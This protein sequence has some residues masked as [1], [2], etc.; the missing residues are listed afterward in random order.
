MDTST[1]QPGK[2]L[3]I[4]STD[5]PRRIAGN[6]SSLSGPRGFSY[7]H[8]LELKFFRTLRRILEN[9]DEDGICPKRCLSTCSRG[10]FARGQRVKDIVFLISERSKNPPGLYAGS[11]KFKR[12]KFYFFFFSTFSSP[13]VFRNSGSRSIETVFCSRFIRSRTTTLFSIASFCPMIST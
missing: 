13:S 7:K 10:E 4:R 12:E 8:S 5:I 3:G 11:K 6:A 1:H 2:N 9:K